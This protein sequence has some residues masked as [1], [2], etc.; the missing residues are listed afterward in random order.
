MNEY[1]MKITYFDTLYKREATLNVFGTIDFED[2]YVYFASC[3]HKHCVRIQ[4]IIKIETI[5][6]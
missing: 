5:E 4:Y 1:G 2:G 6:D 3:G